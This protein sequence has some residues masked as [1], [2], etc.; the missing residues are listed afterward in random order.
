M[1]DVSVENIKKSFE[2]IEMNKETVQRELKAA[3]TAIGAVP[4]RPESI[5]DTLGLVYEEVLY[6]PSQDKYLNKDEYLQIAADDPGRTVVVFNPA[7]REWLP[8][9]L[10][11]PQCYWRRWRPF[12]RPRSRLF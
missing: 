5:E 6:D 8:Q 7:R 4:L 3:S 11:V 9:W 2:Y 1:K 10:R 12:Q